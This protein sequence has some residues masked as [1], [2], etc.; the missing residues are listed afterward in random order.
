MTP[1]TVPSAPLG[2]TGSPGSTEVTVSWQPPASDGGAAVT[3]FTVVASPG[4]QSCSTSGALAC[5]VTG[6]TNGTPYSFVVTA[7]NSA[8]TSSPSVA[9][10]PVTPKAPITR[11]SAVRSLKVTPGRG[12]VRVSWAAPANA[13]GA[14]SLMY[15]YQVGRSK[16]ETTSA[17]SVVVPGRKGARVIVA[18]RA[19]NEAGAGPTVSVTGIPR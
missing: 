16:W 3:S 12:F 17:L 9:S 5:T 14:P 15:E 2:V 11:P 8:G 1:R 18:V 4:G 7:T 13:G 6:L 19:V 10:A